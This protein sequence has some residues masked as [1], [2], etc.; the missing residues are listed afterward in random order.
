MADISKIKIPSGDTYNMKDATAR[1]N[2]T[3][4]TNKTT[5]LAYGDELALNGDTLSLLDPN[6]NVLS[7]VTLGDKTTVYKFNT[8]KISEA[9]AY[10]IAGSSSK[11]YI[12]ALVFDL[13]PITGGWASTDEFELPFI[14]NENRAAKLPFR[15]AKNETSNFTITSNT[16]YIIIDS[17]EVVKNGIL[18]AP[19]YDAQNVELYLNQPD[20]AFR[21]ATKGFAVYT[22][23]SMFGS[24]IPDRAYMLIACMQKS[25]APTDSDFSDMV[26]RF[27]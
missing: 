10:D 24:F 18:V 12:K 2:I 19:Q 25:S 21:N 14:D 22:F 20:S 4:I 13:G 27:I 3:K 26:I 16:N 6:D 15:S 11:P 5:K 9:T 7:S 17:V 8:N 23:A 1:S